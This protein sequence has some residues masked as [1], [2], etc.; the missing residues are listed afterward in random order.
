MR[1]K[2]RKIGNSRGIIIPSP[3][4]SECDIAAEAEIRLEGK[5]IVIQGPKSLRAGWF[6]NYHADLEPS[7]TEK[8]WDGLPPGEDSTEWEW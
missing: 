3:F 4:L 5:N 7:E 1:V 6:D 8:L 2:V